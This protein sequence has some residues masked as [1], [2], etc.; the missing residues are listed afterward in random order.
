M[1]QKTHSIGQS[2]QEIIKRYKLETDYAE[3]VLKENWFG[4]KNK[5]LAQISKP[6]SFKD[7]CLTIRVQNELWLKEFKHKKKELLAM[8]KESFPGITITELKIV[9]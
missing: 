8:L 3:H 9:S 5:Q 4:Q 2:L 6:I 7:N 1:R